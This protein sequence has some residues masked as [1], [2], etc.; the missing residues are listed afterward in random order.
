MGAAFAILSLGCGKS[1]VTLRE[2]WGALHRE[3]EAAFAAAGPDRLAA[4]GGT[5]THGEATVRDRVA[6]LAWHEGY[7]LGVIGACRKAAG[8]AG[9]A[10]LARAAAEH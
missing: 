1:L 3:L 2:A 8:L 5:G 10:E 4:A 6:F 9:P 7:H